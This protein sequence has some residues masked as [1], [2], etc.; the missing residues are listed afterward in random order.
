M[1]IAPEQIYSE[2]SKALQFKS[3]LG[4]KGIYEQ[5]KLNERFYIGDQWYGANC[6]NERPLVRYNIIKRIGDY[7]MSQIVSNPVKISFLADGIPDTVKS[8]DGVIKTKREISENSDFKFTG[9]PDGTEIN[10]LLSVLCDYREVTAR[11]L[12]FENL[13]GKLL[14]KA[15]IGGASVLYTYWDDNIKSDTMPYGSISGD[16]N[17]EVLDIENVY[18][19]DPFKSDVQSQPFII[20]ASKRS[21]EDVIREAENYGGD[22]KAL[23]NL[24]GGKKENKILVLTKLY[25]EYKS[26]G[27]CL[28]KCVKVT[29]NATVRKPFDTGLSLYPIA[30]FN[31]EQRSNLAYGESEITYLIPNQIAINRMITANVWSA[32][33]M[34]MPLM[35]V[36]GDTVT[37]DITNDPGQIIKVYG[38]NEDVEG[39]V[40][41][42]TPPQN[43]GDFS[44]AIS[45]LIK[46]TLSQ[47]GA[48]ETA[49]GESVGENATALAVL[50]SAANLPMRLI[51]NRYYAFLEQ[52]TGIWLD[53]WFSK[54]GERYIK[55]EDANGVWYFPFN[56]E[57]Y[58]DLAVSV[59]ADADT[60]Q[61]FTKSESVNMLTS[62]YDKGII[63]KEQ[64]LKR[65]PAELIPDLKELLKAKEDKNDGI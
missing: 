13:C 36:N 1:N 18:F 8:K 52:I 22:L 5:N 43:F 64:Y 3:S 15:Y 24:S 21:A 25:K 41:Y 27:K 28:I 6:G 53:F 42:I 39:A 50:Q 47:S 37:A 61:K 54:Y 33:T 34:G 57:R 2:Y 60:T 58:K 55:I 4:S 19:A 11:R 46:N 17:C 38:T 62:L 14:K 44:A 7:K 59:R 45:E 31:W 32:M 51:K 16:I 12:K 63:D 48:N 23:K 29:E 10:S 30:V 49:L 35:V 40:R 56:S 65:L 9:K 26:N 20:I